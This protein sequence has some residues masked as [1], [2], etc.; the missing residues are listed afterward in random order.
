MN[1][2]VAARRLGIHYQTA[3]RYVRSGYLIAIKVGTGYEIS[4][5]AIERFLAGRHAIELATESE[6]EHTALAPVVRSPGSVTGELNAL[7]STTT[8][9]TR[10]ILDLVTQH[11]AETV[12][13]FAAIRLLTDDKAWLVGASSNHH[14]P[15]HRATLAAV[16]LQPQVAEDAVEAP[17]LREG[18]VHRVDFVRVDVARQLI[19]RAFHQ[20]AD[21]LTVYSL[22]SAPIIG[23]S[24]QVLGVVTVARDLPG[25]PYT[26][27]EERVVVEMAGW[28]ASAINRVT[29]F[30]SGWNASHTLHD[31]IES[32]LAAHPGATPEELEEL[33]IQVFDDTVPEAVFTLDRQLVVCNEPFTQRVGID[34][35]LTPDTPFSDYAA[36]ICTVAMLG[37]GWER[38][39]SGETDYLDQM[40]DGCAAECPIA[41][42]IHW[43]VAHL[44]DATPAYVIA[45]CSP[46][47]HSS[48]GTRDGVVQYR[49][50]CQ[51]TPR[52]AVG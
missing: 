45:T 16:L 26:A 29:H 8:L 19:P 42:G 20:Y 15:V 39:V 1:L 24:G 41:D 46:H 47:A 10:P 25:H 2:K 52:P 11:L 22:V 17:A 44:P 28:V 35:Q 13:D 36:A 37:D 12:G 21:L 7:L 40:A 23:E 49:T 3:Y 5:A 48:T 38:L 31:R 27:D 9:S 33:V 43:A 18:R 51:M 32:L 50:L 4:E 14:D 6:L 30:T 34:P